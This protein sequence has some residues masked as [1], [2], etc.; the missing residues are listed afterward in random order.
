M[1]FKHG[2]H[3]RQ[4]AERAGCD[5]ED[6]L[7][8]SANINPIGPPPSLRAVVARTIDRVVHY[9]DPDC[10]QLVHA[11]AHVDDVSP[12]QV[13]VGNGSTEILHAIVRLQKKMRAVVPVPSYTDYADISRRAGMK[14]VSIPLDA[15][16]DFKLEWAR[17][18]ESL[19]GDEIVFLGRPNNPTGQLFEADEFRLFAARYPNSIF[20]VDEAFADFVS[21]IESIAKKPSAN[22]VVLRSLTKFYAIPGI[23]LG[24]AIA[25]PEIAGMIREEI[26]NWS[27]NTLAQTIGVSALNDLDYAERTRSYVDRAR[28][29][30]FADLS[31]ISSL[32]VFPGCANFLLVRLLR[33]DIDGAA[34]AQQLLE[35]RIAIRCCEN[36]DNLDGS[37]FRVAV[38]KESDNRK[39]INALR[40]ILSVSPSRGGRPAS[41]RTPSLMLQGTSSNA[42]KSIIAAAICRILVQDGVRV[43]PFKSQNMSLNSFVTSEGAEM[44]RAQVV[45]AQA[46][47]LE[48]DVCMNPILLKPNSDTGC[49]VIV[50]GQPVG[51]MKVA[52]YIRYKPKAFEA[53]TQC[54]DSLA[55]KYDAVILEGA[56]SPAEI[57]LKH[58][59]IVNM[60]MARYADASVLLV[61]DIDRGGLFASF[62]G[63]MEL[64]T[65][66]ERRQVFGFLI[67][68][69]RGDA[70]LLGP[71]IEYILSH[72]GKPTLGVVP[73][74]HDLGLPEEDSVEFKTG[75]P[76]MATR[77][78]DLIDIAVIDLPHISNLTDLD[79]L[80]IESDVHVRIVRNVQ[81]LGMPDAVILPGS[82]NVPGD[83]AFIKERGF[84]DKLCKI[85][86]LEKTEIIGIC[87]GFQIL[88]RTITD[89]ARVESEG[90]PVEGLGLLAVTTEL[91]AD[92]MLALTSAIHIPSGLEVV[93][94]EIHH[95]RTEV[96]GDA[97]LFRAENEMII[98]VANRSG[99]IWGTYLH[100]VFDADPFRRWLIDRLRV[101]RGL[102]PLE[103]ISAIYD[104]SPALDR[105]AD[106]V[107]E[108]LDMDMIYKRMGL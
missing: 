10:H 108:S 30:L 42:G 16:N 38:G 49:Q 3:L 23:R 37:Y 4:L 103:K 106:I 40:A 74:I 46:C 97:P 55:K 100:G 66:A 28:G 25:A 88:G 50:N 9:P 87:G 91:A 93:G 18:G 63:T 32:R 92:K 85:A 7:D 101:R 57:N 35:R 56:G 22:V 68:R 6:L 39:L 61:G 54:Y 95:G 34:L 47:N 72:T 11:I 36:I 58:H 99:N 29:N 79:A 41:K 13:V 17:L 33:S 98:G 8:F 48:P 26:P 86:L 82:K 78:E 104:I 60:E 52:E 89:P 107:R 27:V 5:T 64:L 84:A 83:L 80:R 15:S 19:H 73:Y 43:A 67:N 75:T 70:S 71:A 2:G 31:K 76:E 59:D 102:V 1:T 53:A 14:I 21:D 94:Y 96:C 81:Q 20:V 62:V 12:E 24:I 65:P 44:G 77:Q 45:Q 69:F 90:A 105:L 51:N